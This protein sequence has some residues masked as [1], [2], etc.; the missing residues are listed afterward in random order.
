[1]HGAVW[2][3]SRSSTSCR[4][5]H[6][7]VPESTVTA[8]PG[9]RC[10]ACCVPTM[11]PAVLVSS[12]LALPCMSESRMPPPGGP[13]T[14]ELPTGAPLSRLTGR[15][16]LD[17]GPRAPTGRAQGHFSRLPPLASERAA[18][19]GVSLGELR[20]RERASQFQCTR[21]RRPGTDQRPSATQKFTGT[22]SSP[23]I[24]LTK[25]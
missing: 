21:S 24:N 15:P 9:A 7:T 17:S 22:G 25:T 2:P 16:T 5:G 13:V 1:M 23:S 19:P 8:R 6:C 18:W 14:R 11:E 20:S 10:R 4:P 3:M 12:Q